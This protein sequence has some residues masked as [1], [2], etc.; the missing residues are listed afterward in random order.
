MV[1]VA[2]ATRRTGRVIDSRVYVAPK[3]KCVAPGTVVR[4]T[5]VRADDTGAVVSLYTIHCERTGRAMARNGYDM[6][7]GIVPHLKNHS[8]YIPDGSWVTFTVKK[9]M[10]MRKRLRNE[11]GDVKREDERLKKGKYRR[12]ATMS[13]EKESGEEEE[14]EG[15][16]EKEGGGKGSEGWE[17]VRELNRL[18]EE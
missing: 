2:M 3:A 12:N 6:L 13:E 16:N 1:A 17:M 8:A 9:E 7:H 4:N 10:V 5:A 15:E 11:N 14:G 18:G